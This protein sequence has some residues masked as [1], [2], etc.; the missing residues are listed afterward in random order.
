[1]RKNLT[2]SLSADDWQKVKAI[3]ESLGETYSR[4]FHHFIAL[5]AGTD[6]D[7]KRVSRYRALL[8]P[9]SDFLSRRAKTFATVRGKRRLPA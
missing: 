7:E 9:H 1:M 6:R 4:V 3:A 2:I 5:G 8:A